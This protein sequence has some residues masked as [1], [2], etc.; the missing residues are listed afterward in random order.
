MGLTQGL[1][2][3]SLITED[4]FKLLHT[5]IPGKMSGYR[6][7]S[8]LDDSTEL[9]G[10]SRVTNYAIRALLVS[11]Q[12]RLS[13][14]FVQAGLTTGKHCTIMSLSLVSGQV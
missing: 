14:C 5:L 11:P 1:E 6:F 7:H 3:E 8:L 10:E 4:T 9:T 13:Q 2:T 12:V